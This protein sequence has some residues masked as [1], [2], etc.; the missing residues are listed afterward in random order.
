MI[1][2]A[3][4]PETNRMAPNSGMA[5][6]QPSPQAVESRLRPTHGEYHSETGGHEHGSCRFQRIDSGQWPRTARVTSCQTP[7]PKRRQDQGDHECLRSGG[8]RVK[9]QIVENEGF[10]YCLG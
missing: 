9:S 5:S 3:H 7:R 1:W 4:Q 8:H 2:P 10:A 6:Y